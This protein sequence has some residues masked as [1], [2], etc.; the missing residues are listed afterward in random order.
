M[1][2]PDVSAAAIF[3]AGWMTVPCPCVASGGLVCSICAPRSDAN[4]VL[5]GVACLNCQGT[6]KVHPLQEKCKCEG[7]F[8]GHPILAC[9]WPD[10][11][12]SGCKNRGYLPR[13]NFNA[14]TEAIRAKGWQAE[15]TVAAIGYEILIGPPE[16]ILAMVA[17]GDV[18]NIEDA[19]VVALARAGGW[20]G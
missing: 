9:G 19:V 18:D 16:K 17:F 11:W 3:L 12:D 20:N 2:K 10:E 4:V 7:K 15:I 6:G 13:I 8:I 14:L 1:T 5:H